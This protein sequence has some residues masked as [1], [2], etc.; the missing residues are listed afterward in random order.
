MSQVNH[1]EFTNNEA[2]EQQAR[3]EK[4][5]RLTRNGT[6]WIV[7][8]AFL[9]GS[10]FVLNYFMF[11]SGGSF[12]WYMYG[13]TTLGSICILKGLVDILGF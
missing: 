8:G 11:H 4:H 12:G 13:F 5:Q 9:M 6:L 3:K 2:I 7:A 10:S 1:D